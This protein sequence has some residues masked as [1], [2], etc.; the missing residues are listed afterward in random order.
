MARKVSFS[1]GDAK[2]IA[3][4]TRAYERGNRDQP[5]IRFRGGGSDDGDPIRIGKTIAV[6]AKDTVANIALYESGT[7]P[8][9][10]SSSAALED[11]V[12]KFATVGCDKW[13]AVARAANGRWYLI[14]AECG[15]DEGSG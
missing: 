4:A 6:W 10:T 5:P 8:N 14:A 3:A 7:P 15:V 2:R 11:C 9:E 1:E 12:N 13:V